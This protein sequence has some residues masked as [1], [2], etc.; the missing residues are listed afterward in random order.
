M[1]LGFSTLS[2]FL[3]PLDEI[4]DT[5]K[6]DG[7]EVI[8]ILSE[9][10]YAAYNIEKNDEI[11]KISDKGNI[12]INIHGPTVDLNLASINEGIRR[13]SVK[14]TIET[15]DMANKIGANAITVHPGKIGRKDDKLRKYAL[16]LA[17]ESIGQ[18][19]DYGKEHGNIKISVENLPERYSFLGNKVEEIEYIQENTDSKITIDTGH[20]NTCKDC[21]E[22]FK[23]KNIEYFHINDNN[24]IKDQHLILGEGTLDLNLLKYID[25]GIIELN[26]YE[27]VLKTQELIRSLGY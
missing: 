1:K 21:Q 11:I 24:K 6:R 12:E 22:F 8:E 14:Q 4:L 26:T 18:C 9:G 15:I 20:A 5:A 27:K 3:K 10:P 19:V 7:F 13:E 17:V 16:D 23:L 25:K 2:L